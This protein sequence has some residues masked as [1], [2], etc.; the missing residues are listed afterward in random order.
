MEYL[1]SPQVNSIALIILP[2][3]FAEGAQSSVTAQSHRAQ[4]GFIDAASRDDPETEYCR[5]LWRAV[6]G[7]QIA[8]AKTLSYKLEKQL[9]KA[10]ALEWIFG[11][12]SDFTMVCD[13]AGWDAQYV[14]SLCITAHSHGFC[15]RPFFSYRQKQK[16]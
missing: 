7:Q 4:G 9:L 10:Q 2:P 13:L 1:N 3:A 8:D 14:R 15:R 5:A 12:E 16:P 6:I 11:N